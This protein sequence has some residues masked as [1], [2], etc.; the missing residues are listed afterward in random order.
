MITGP[1]IVDGPAP[2]KL[3]ACPLPARARE[4]RPLFVLEQTIYQ[5]TPYGWQRIPRG[6]VT[7]FGS[8]PALASTLTLSDLRPL[9]SHAWA[10]LGHDW[11]YA[12]GQPGR[13][14]IADEIFLHQMELDKVA[15]LK[16][17]IMYRAV[18]LGGGGGFEKAKT[19]WATENF[20]D[21]D[22]ENGRPVIPPF[23]R[24]EAFAG[25][26]WGLR[27]RPDWNETA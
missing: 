3:P 13:R 5:R 9:G 26:R 16:R 10:A 18:R 2:G 19:W 6:Y 24:E 25:K 22:D 1:L 15:A 4:E 14:A 12:I 17:S 27:D 7:D 20:A 21:P 11:Q 8:I 23:D